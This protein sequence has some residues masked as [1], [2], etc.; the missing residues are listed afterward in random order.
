MKQ[1]P[2]YIILNTLIVDF[3]NCNG[4]EAFSC[5]SVLVNLYMYT[6]LMLFKKNRARKGF[7][8]EHMQR[9]SIIL[10]R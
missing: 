1:I 7:T 9:C 6:Y 8:N 2:A 10:F 3:L 4:H 5:R